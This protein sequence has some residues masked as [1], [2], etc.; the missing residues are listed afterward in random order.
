MFEEIRDMKGAIIPEETS[1]AMD[2][3]RDAL[4]SSRDILRFE[5]E[6][7]KIYMVCP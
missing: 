1:K 3:F 2:D 6:G 5:S 4:E 7:S